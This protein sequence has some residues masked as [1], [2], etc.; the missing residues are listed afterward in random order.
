MFVVSIYGWKEETPELV[1]ALAGALGIIAFEARQRL[2][3]GG[4]SVVASFADRS[5][6]GELAEKVS[7]CGVRTLIVDAKAVRMRDGVLIV[8]RFVF[9]RAGLKIETHTGH[10]ETIPYAEMELFV[11]GTSVVGYNETQTV[12]EKKLDLGKTLLS[13][14][15]PMTKKV[16]RQEVVSTEESEQRL[17]LYAHGR[18]AT[19][20]SL[21]G[22][23]YDGFGAEMK[24]SR[25]LNF[26]HL[27][28]QLRL[29]AVGAAFDDRLLS[30]GN[31][32]RLLGPAQGHEAS[33][34][35]AA[36]ILARCLLETAKSN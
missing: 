27:I 19:I 6:A 36:E 15:I 1:Q 14:G 8:R 31:Q 11:T 3:G 25:K 17:Y 23:N 20:F 24:L 32:V 16:E 7:R 30:R 13:G 4:P 29:H 12:V 9:E 21:H 26:A 33:L 28:S 34:D 2:F 18:P 22:I 35:L 5:Q 10:Q